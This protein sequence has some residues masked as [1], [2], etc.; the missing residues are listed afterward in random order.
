VGGHTLY[1][2]SSS[3]P[4]RGKPGTTVDSPNKDK[5]ML[6]NGENGITQ[7][8]GKQTVDLNVVSL[9]NPEISMS[10]NLVNKDLDLSLL[11]TVV[12]D[13]KE[14]YQYVN[15]T[16]FTLPDGRVADTKGIFLYG[17]TSKDF[18]IDGNGAMKTVG[19][20]EAGVFWIPQ[21]RAAVDTSVIL[22]QSMELA[23]SA[24]KSFLRIYLD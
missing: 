5:I 9:N 13:G 24:E 15:T 17:G 21:H 19:P 3:C 8:R 10:G 18:I 1:Y 6:F 2:G 22:A 16:A 7:A 20:G 4:A 14:Q 11:G 12:K 23:M